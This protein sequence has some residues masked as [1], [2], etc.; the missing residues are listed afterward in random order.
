[1]QALFEQRDAPAQARLGH[2]QRAARGGETTVVHHL[3]EIGQVVEIGRRHCSTYETV[4][5]IMPIYRRQ[6]SIRIIEPFPVHRGV[7]SGEAPCSKPFKPCSAP[8]ARIGWAT[9]FPCVRCSAT[10]TT[11]PS[12]APSCCWTT[13]APPP[14]PRPSA[15]VAWACTRTAASRP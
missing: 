4:K 8:R 5:C 9:V 1:T 2:P 6:C 3:G 15:S 10:A 12:S 11:A 13:P 14:S 7:L